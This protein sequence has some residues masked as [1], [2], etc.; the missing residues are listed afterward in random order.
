MRIDPWVLTHATQST[1]SHS[2]QR[3]FVRA[4][5]STSSSSGSQ[6]REKSRPRSPATTPAM[7]TAN[8]MTM[9]ATR[10]P[11]APRARA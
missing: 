1:G 10:P 9:A 11:R 5:V 8:S 4:F 6:T 2:S 7:P 3:G